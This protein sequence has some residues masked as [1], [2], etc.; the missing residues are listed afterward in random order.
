[1]NINPNQH[2]TEFLN[3][4]CSLPTAPQY[5]IMLK[6]KWG[7]GKT[8]FIN[9]YKNVLKENN[10]KYIYVSLY[11]VT[12][13]DEIETKFLEV[14]HPKLYNKKTILAGKIAKGLLKTTLKIDL[15]D[16]GKS[17]GTIRSE[18]PNLNTGDL[19]NTKDYILIF[20]DLE[21]CSIDINDLLGYIN[22]FVEHQEY[23]VILLAN[24]EKFKSEE[25]K[26]IKEK[27]IGKT[28]EVISNTE[29]AYDSF[30]K[31]I[32]ENNL[33]IDYKDTII[34]I[35]IQSGYNNLRV[36]R[37]VIL[38]FDRFNQSINLN[39]FKKELVKNFVTEYFIF[40][41]ENRFQSYTISK[42]EKS[43]KD[44]KSSL[45]AY[46]NGNDT[47][48]DK[49]NIYSQ[50]IKKYNS[51][52]F[53]PY[54]LSF[55][56]WSDILN[57]SIIEKKN[58]ME[59]FHK[60]KYSFDKNTLSWIKL[61]N[62]T[63]IKDEGF[64]IL[65]S[66]V[67]L[68]IKKNNYTNLD[69]IL[70]I[71]TLLL[72]LQENKLYAIEKEELLNLIYQNIDYIFE[73]NHL[74]E[75]DF[76]FEKTLSRK[77]NYDKDVYTYYQKKENVF[78]KETMQS[79]AIQIL[80][81]LKEKDNRKVYTLLSFSNTERNYKDKEILSIINIQ[82]L[83]DI[84]VLNETNSAYFFG[85]ILNDRYTNYTYNNNL[86]HEMSFLKELEQEIEKEYKKRIGEV[87]GYNLKTYFL[88]SS[89]PKAINDL[90]ADIRNKEKNEIH[91]KTN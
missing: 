13:Y 44:D 16:D 55:K 69:D 14:L 61:Q 36:F 1:M 65:L 59:T 8:H 9:E 49:E 88:K 83:I 90:Q 43:N 42:F 11:G 84:L 78:H 34:K 7:S 68:N 80:K 71:S 56:T 28:F 23:K 77:N 32:K 86:I 46:I 21:R 20:D 6:G 10:K 67:E 35:Y 30:I 51:F 4:Y 38:D 47:V 18:A 53:E 60:S 70:N 89:L 63:S 29:L 62:F 72:E 48:P 73:Q 40:A 57:S 17:D 45:E 27:L 82:Q 22:Y 24:D 39:N 85:N 66:D 25:Y 52:L 58:I 5:A 41:I 19:L 2:I 79:D 26:D 64:K 75:D 76:S 50:F 3:Y 91:K 37:Q 81:Y 33:F 87:S 15:D 12:S 54:I 31:E 74:T